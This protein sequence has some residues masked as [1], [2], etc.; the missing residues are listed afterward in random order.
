MGEA[1]G[2]EPNDGVAHLQAAALEMI[3]AAR[4]FLE[5]AEAVV[6]N[7]EAVRTAVVTVG[8]M[9]KAVMQAVDPTSTKA[10]GDGADDQADPPIEHITLS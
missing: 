7:P 8:A 6:Q 9:A 5:V 1:M 3:A 4:A 10:N 2:F